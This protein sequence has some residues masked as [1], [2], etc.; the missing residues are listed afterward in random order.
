MTE[1][2]CIND[3][4]FTP[5]FFVILLLLKYKLF[6][7]ALRGLHRKL[8]HK[9]ISPPWV[10][11]PHATLVLCISSLLCVCSA[12]QL[13]F[14]TQTVAH[15]VPLST[16]LSRQEYWS[17][18]PFPSPGDLPDPR[19]ELTNLHWQAKFFTTKPSGKLPCSC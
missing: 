6:R 2:A 13:C 16:G 10:T 14:A 19:M 1:T 17:G 8:R 7:T 9:K 3:I 15:Q 18:L 5:L 11:I 12:V 4:I